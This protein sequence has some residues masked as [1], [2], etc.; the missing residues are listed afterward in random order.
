MK[1]TYLIPAL[2][3]EEAHATQMLAQSLTIVT[4]DDV[5]IDPTPDPGDG[6]GDSD[7]HVKAWDMDW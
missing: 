7:P 5:G 6:T 4:G 3:V 2:Q 1:K